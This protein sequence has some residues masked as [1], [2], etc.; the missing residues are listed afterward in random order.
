[1]TH[2]PRRRRFL[3]AA[4]GLC[5]LG[6]SG[7][8]AA[9]PQRYAGRADPFT[10]GVASGEPAADGFVIW[11]RLLPEDGAPLPPVPIEVDWEVAGDDGFRQVLR[12]GTAHA[13]PEWGHSV[14]VE[15][16][17]LPPGRPYAYRFS[18]GAMRS[19]SGWSRTLPATGGERLRLALASCQ[20]YED[21]Y[22]A[23]Y[24]HMAG[25]DL[26]LVL[27]LG[28]YLYE[29]NLK[30]PVRAHGHPEPVDLDGY[31]RRHAIYKRDPDLQRAHARHPWMGVWD[32]H[33]VTND[34]AGLWPPTAFGATPPE[35]FALR[36]A[37]AY[38]A[39]YEHMPLRRGARPVAGGMP[40]FRS[41]RV[42]DLATLHLLDTRQYRDRQPC[43]TETWGGGRNAACRERT[44][45]GRTMLGAVQERWLAGRLRE[46]SGV[47]PL[48]VQ[49]LMLAPFERRQDGE[50]R[51]W[52]DGWDGYPAARGR[53]L[54]DIATSGVGAPLVFGGDIHS[55]W[56]SELRDGPEGRALATEIVTTSISSRGVPYA[57]FAADLP[58]NPHIH[59]FE[60]RRRGYTCCTLTR[61]EGRVEWFG[62]ADV[63]DPAS[64]V[65]RVRSF[66]L[67]AGRAG[68]TDA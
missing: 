60:S 10:L 43:A 68:V 34:Y 38:Q 50:A 29:S 22:Y 25:Q 42:G 46:G 47:W 36:R 1:M 48:L 17:G 26:D 44:R 19:R 15:V 31:R 52:T 54:A 61:R 58:H 32:D 59:A 56:A 53:L 49:S 57:A 62:V 23:A 4:A 3:L 12:R 21:G 27:H 37:A 51:W 8:V 41:C 13:L 33:D 35:R 16:S 9:R 6:L 5:G 30:V 14:H 66:A 2:D 11:T 28:D 24:R 18:A 20:H 63:R 39:W 55:W 40:L 7:G 67:E 45:A 64:P 65:V